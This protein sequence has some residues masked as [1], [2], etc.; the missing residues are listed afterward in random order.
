MKKVIVLAAL[1]ISSLVMADSVTLQSARVRV[2]DAADQQQVKLQVKHDFTKNLAGDFSIT[3][4][5][6]DVSNALGNRIE[7]GLTPTLGL[8]PVTGYT[9]V[10]LGQ[11]TSNT[12]AFGYYSIEPGVS[13]P[14]GPVVIKAGIRWRSAT[15]SVVN[16]DQTHTKRIG[17]SYRLTKTDTIGLKYDRVRGDATPNVTAVNY[18]HSF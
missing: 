2:V 7:A 4:T 15:D 12:Q 16:N 18:T 6:T 17:V 5:Q 3:Q 11:K 8:G 14:V 10:A 1:A 13:A 9:R